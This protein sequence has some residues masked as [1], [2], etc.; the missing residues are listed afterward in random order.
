MILLCKNCG[1]YTLEKL[2]PK[3]KLETISIKPA[4]YSLEDKY[5]YYRR[6]AKK[7]VQI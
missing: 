1:R 3:C 2:C 4:K 7:N 6:L 5:G